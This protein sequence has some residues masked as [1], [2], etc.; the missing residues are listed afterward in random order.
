[1]VHHE[2]TLPTRKYALRVLATSR[3]VRRGS[4]SWQT[5]KRRYHPQVGPP[6]T[7]LRARLISFATMSRP[8]RWL[9]FSVIALLVIYGALLAATNLPAPPLA[10][11]SVQGKPTQVSSA[12]YAVTLVSLSFGWTLALTA[13]LLMPLAVRLLLL[14]PVLVLLASGPVTRL[15][16]APSPLNPPSTMELWLRG[17]QLVILGVLAVYSVIG[18][19]PRAHGKA[20]RRAHQQLCAE[21]VA[22]RGADGKLYGGRAGNRIWLRVSRGE[23]PDCRCNRGA[24]ELPTGDT[25]RRG[26]LGQ[27]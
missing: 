20:G 2:G 21:P 3:R 12:I 13:A 11:G 9:A 23:W 10:T 14:T 7:R 5:P 15:A 16:D 1:M 24:G 6:L 18:A 27:H 26:V 4:I 19:R 17:A 22:R 25:G 8:L